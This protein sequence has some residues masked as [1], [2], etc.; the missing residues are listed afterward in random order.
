MA[1]F[2]LGCVLR[3]STSSTYYKYASLENLVR[4]VEHLEIKNQDVNSRLAGPGEKIP[5]Y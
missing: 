2:P 3:G 4:L 1:I 5:H